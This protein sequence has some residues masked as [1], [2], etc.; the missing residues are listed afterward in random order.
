MA[1][2]HE[3]DRYTMGESAQLTY[4]VARAAD[5]MRR[6]G[7]AGPWGRKID[8]LQAQAVAREAAEKAA[9]DKAAADRR[10][11]IAKKKAEGRKWW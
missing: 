6:K 5:H 1:R 4:L 11:E 7:S 2:G 8:Q 9:R 10:A 3:P